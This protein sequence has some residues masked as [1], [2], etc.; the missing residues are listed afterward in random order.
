MYF[1]GGVLRGTIT[2][3]AG[4]G[5]IEFDDEPEA[6]ELPIDFDPRGMEVRVESGGNVAFERIFPE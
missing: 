2:V 6:G 4:Q 5:E 3:A 1:V